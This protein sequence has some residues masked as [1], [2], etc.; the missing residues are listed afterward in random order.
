MHSWRDP[1]VRADRLRPASPIGLT[2]V[3][4]HL[5][6]INVT[7]TWINPARSIGPA[8]VGVASKP[9]AIQSL[10]LFIIAPLIG[11]GAAG[12]LFRTGALLDAPNKP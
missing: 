11:A 6:G 1:S 5:V 10:W 7:R 12:L 4:I 3:V 2:L 8:L 9:G